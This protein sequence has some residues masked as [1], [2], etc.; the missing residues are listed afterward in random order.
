MG[1]NVD[2]DIFLTFTLLSENCQFCSNV[3]I[4][5]LKKKKF[6]GVIVHNWYEIW[7][8]YLLVSL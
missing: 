5:V 8:W 4:F 7:K 3:Q 2:I 6:S 1:E